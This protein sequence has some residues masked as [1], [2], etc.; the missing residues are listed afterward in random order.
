MLLRSRALERLER[1]ENGQRW[2]KPIPA[3][4]VGRGR[5]EP[6]QETRGEHN[7]ISK[8]KK[9]LSCRPKIGKNKN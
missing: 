2:K 8:D 4:A 7:T 1:R 3:I 6:E 5:N 9:S